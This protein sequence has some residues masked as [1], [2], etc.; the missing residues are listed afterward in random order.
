MET[1]AQ[2]RSR[3][4]KL[5][6]I[7]NKPVGALKKLFDPEFEPLWEKMG[8][9]D[10]KI[11][12]EAENLK[13]Y[14]K[15]AKTNFN[16]REYMTTIRF[17]G[18]FHDQI[19]KIDKQLADLLTSV[20]VKHHEFLF[21]ELAP[22]DLKYLTEHLGP[23][24]E[25]KVPT[26][27]RAFIEKEAGITDWWHN[28]STDR[29]R[30][31]AAYEKRFSK[32]AKELKRQTGILI[33]KSEQLYNLVIVTF[34]QFGV[35]Y[36]T[37]KVEEYLKLAEKLRQK[38]R[39]YTTAFDS[40]YNTYVKKYIEI[41]RAMQSLP[42]AQNPIEEI[43]DVPEAK[44]PVEE[45]KDAPK[46]NAPASLENVTPEGE[47]PSFSPQA[48]SAVISDIPPTLPSEHPQF[49]KPI[50][51]VPKDTEEDTPEAFLVKKKQVPFR[52]SEGPSSSA[53]T[54]PAPTLSIPTVPVPG[55]AKTPGGTMMSPGVPSRHTVPYKSPEVSP[56]KVDLTNPVLPKPPKSPVIRYDEPT[57]QEANKYIQFKPDQSTIETKRPVGKV[58]S[59]KEFLDHL[60]K[61]SSESPFVVATYIIKYAR[62]IKE[63]DLEMSEKLT[64]I[65][66]NILKG[67]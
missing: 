21:G 5:R 7:V 31:L 19:E 61:L 15:V 27:K 43:K 13:E 16:R 22:E 36:A 60:T 48:P 56:E 35:Y 1:F 23:K 58:K 34:K 18:S 12:E 4:N 66:Q 26:Q 6:E 44:T 9:V 38:F 40:Y 50:S 11:R 46:A 10:E 42:D 51:S 67:K 62:H 25:R 20:D 59:H 28:I 47:L 29:G 33:N 17:L 30:Q 64:Q 52:P 41:Q 54:V 14:V 49:P 65:A 39:A 8:E 24:F 53:I 37:R 45:I 2:K 32:D 55:A 57:E 3:L 63:A